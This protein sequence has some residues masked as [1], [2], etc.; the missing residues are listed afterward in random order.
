MGAKIAT[1][2]AIG[3]AFAWIAAEIGDTRPDDTCWRSCLLRWSA[4][5]IGL[6][7]CATFYGWAAF[8]APLEFWRLPLAWA[9]ELLRHL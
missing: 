1:L 6:A 4:T 5:A 7:G 9:G 8:G 3:V 2:V